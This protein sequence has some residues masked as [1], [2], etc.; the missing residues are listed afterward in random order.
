[1]PVNATQMQTRLVV[2]PM[3]A[4]VLLLPIQ[5]LFLLSG[6]TTENMGRQKSLP[7]FI[8]FSAAAAL[9]PGWA[10]VPLL[11]RLHVKFRLFS[12]DEEDEDVKS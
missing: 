10:L 8:T 1:M 7:F 4:L 11:R 3:S 5:G 9:F 12:S 2:I 6:V